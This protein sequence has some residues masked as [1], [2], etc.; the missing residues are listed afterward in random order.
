MESG[1]SVS[2]QADCGKNAL[3]L[4]VKSLQ[5]RDLRVVGLSNQQE[6]SIIFQINTTEQIVPEVG[7][8]KE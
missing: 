7:Y 5:G 6:W 2:L 1:R 4:Y 8:I 3:P